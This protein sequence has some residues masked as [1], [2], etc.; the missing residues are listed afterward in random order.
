MRSNIQAVIELERDTRRGRTFLERLTDVVSATA[1]STTFIVA[2]V[3]WFGAWVGINVWS[4]AR[5]DPYP[6]SLLTWLVSLEA[7]MLTGFVLISQDRM[8][9]LADKRAHLDL[10]VN[11]LA[12]QELTAILK[13]VCLIAEKTGVELQGC[14]PNLDQLLGK[15]DVKQLHDELTKELAKD[16]S[17]G[18]ERLPSGG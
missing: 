12:E 11:L 1:S 15:T 6:F 3:V 2:H 18:H 8:T 17:G 7:I 4:P 14:H 5:F 9:K 13:V 16:V 10:Q